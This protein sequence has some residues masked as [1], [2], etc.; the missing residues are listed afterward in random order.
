MTGFKFELGETLQDK[1]TPFRG[2]VMART[3][4]LT[5]C[6]QY[7][8]SSQQLTDGHLTDWEWMDES[9]LERVAPMVNRIFLNEA[10]DERSGF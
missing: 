10:S 7:A 1:I 6:L 5:G 4:F 3:E 2:V 9:R 8:I